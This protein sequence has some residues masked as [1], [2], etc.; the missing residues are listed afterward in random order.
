MK[1][2]NSWPVY[3]RDDVE[4][5]VRRQDEINPLRRLKLGRAHARRRTD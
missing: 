4:E 1:A 5:R 2:V 3:V